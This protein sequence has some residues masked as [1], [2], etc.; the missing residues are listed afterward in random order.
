MGVALR[1][2][3]D[4]GTRAIGTSAVSEST[5]DVPSEL[6]EVLS[7]RNGFLA[8][9]SALLVRSWHDVDS[10]QGIASWNALNNWRHAYGNAAEGL[11]FFA[12]DLFGCQFALSEHGIVRFNP[13]TGD[14]DHFGSTIENWARLILADHRGATGWPVG[15]DWQ[16][17]FGMLPL[18]YR[19]APR[20]PFVLG[21]DYVVSN[22][23]AEKDDR[24]MRNLAN[25]CAAI[26]NIPDGARVEISGWPYQELT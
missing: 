16:K 12:E 11:V 9:E 22:L 6:R 2:L 21:G 19:L 17:A 24:L 1:K 25:V 23:V 26:R 18:G 4:L 14:R 10:M 7:L 13:E 15:H 3:V 5:P 8:F 20:R